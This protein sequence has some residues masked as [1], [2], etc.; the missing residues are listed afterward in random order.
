MTDPHASHTRRGGVVAAIV[1]LAVGLL[2][3]AIGTIGHRHHWRFDEVVIPWGLVLALAGVAALL[4]GIRLLYPGRLIAGAA[5]LGVI[6]SVAVLSLPGVGGSV[7]VPA[8]IEGTIWTIAPAV[9]GVL[10]VAWPSSSAL[11]RTTSHG[12]SG[13]SASA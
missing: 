1:G 4:I 7:L 9:I 11:R 5:A 3:G 10:V 12:A 6:V 13:A 2:Y 8:T